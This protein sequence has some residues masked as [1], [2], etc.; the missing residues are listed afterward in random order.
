[1]VGAFIWLCF[2]AM[3]T[4]HFVGATQKSVCI[5]YVMHAISAFIFLVS[6]VWTITGTIIRYSHN[7]RV[8]SGEYIDSYDPPEQNTSWYMQKSGKFMQVYL[9]IS[10]ISIII[11]TI[12]VLFVFTSVCI[13]FLCLGKENKERKE[14]EASIE[15]IP[16][17]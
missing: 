11:F 10:W 6:I 9:L 17:A 14:Y 16:D 5:V 15:R 4:G 1:M 7:G 3:R 13:I 8:C 12:F 2:L